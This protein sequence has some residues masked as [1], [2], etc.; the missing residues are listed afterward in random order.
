MNNRGFSA[1]FEN[2]NP[3]TIITVVTF[4]GDN[5]GPAQFVT[6]DPSTGLVTLKEFSSVTPSDSVVVLLLADRIES[7]KFG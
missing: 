4:S 6:F 2:M 7:I 3:G 1:V 5:I